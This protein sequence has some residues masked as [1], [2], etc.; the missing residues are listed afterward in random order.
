MEQK[1][2]ER[3]LPDSIILED[4][5]RKY[6]TS[7]MAVLSN[8][9]QAFNELLADRDIGDSLPAFE[10]LNQE[11]LDK[12]VED[13]IAAVMASPHPYDTRVES[14]DEW[15]EFKR[16]IQA[17]IKKID[18]LR[19]IDKQAKV[20]A[21]GCHLCFVNMDEL[22]SEKS[23]FVTPD[24][25]HSYYALV[26]EVHEAVMRLREFEAQN[27]DKKI[28]PLTMIDSM[29]ENPKEFIKSLIIR[30]NLRKFVNQEQVSHIKEQ[31]AASLEE[32]AERNR[33]Y[34][35]EREEAHAEYL[36]KQQ[37]KRQELIQNGHEV[38]FTTGIRDING[39]VIPIGNH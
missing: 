22:I 37:E 25:F 7:W 14:A 31:S 20:E 5:H 15:R 9:Q 10:T 35:K 19:R 21:K 36:R 30:E 24:Q 32:Q 29:A 23:R 2:N 4:E 27:L 6:R 34:Q 28:I 38:D 3:K 8:A 16:D 26:V 33:Q 12:F 39:N 11:W 17:K 1:K 18:A 13:K